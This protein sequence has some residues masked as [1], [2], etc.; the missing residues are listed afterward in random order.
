[1]NEAVEQ[2]RER[3]LASPA[4]LARL[5]AT[6]D[7]EAFIIATL[8]VAAEMQIAVTATDIKNALRAARRDYI[9]RWD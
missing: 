3:V 1:M 7:L 6:S 4:L 9:E 8:D 2:L 5:R